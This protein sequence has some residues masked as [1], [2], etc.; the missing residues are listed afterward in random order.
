MEFVRR[1]KYCL[2]CDISKFYPTI[3]HDILYKIICKK[4]RCKDTLA[5]LKNIVYSTDG[6]P[7]GNY[8][9]QWFGNLY[10]NELD[11]FVKQTHR[12]KA[13]IRYC[14]DFLLFHN[15][16]SYLRELSIKMQDFVWT[17]LR[18][19]LSKCDLFPVSRGVDF[20][21][22]RH[23]KDCILLRKSTVKRVKKRLGN[24]P[25]QLHK[26]NQLFDSCVSSIASTLGWMQH[27]NCFNLQ[28]M[29]GVIS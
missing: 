29:I 2:K 14:D 22:Y 19:V 1:Y 4:V 5:L 16:R 17:N 7:I 25:N 15:D 18:L 12:I 13:Y 9:S 23:F 6:V 10:L 11:F 27:G 21:G 24:L 3:N 28:Q 8:T 26:G 20:L